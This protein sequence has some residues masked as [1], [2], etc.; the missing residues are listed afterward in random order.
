MFTIHHWCTQRQ[1]K[2]DDGTGRVVHV[3]LLT[4]VDGKHAIPYVNMLKVRTE[5]P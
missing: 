5:S 3:R 1:V 4:H 2:L